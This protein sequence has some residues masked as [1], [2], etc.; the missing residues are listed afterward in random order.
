MSIVLCNDKNGNPQLCGRCKTQLEK[1][2]ECGTDYYPTHVGVVLQKY[3]SSCGIMLPL[4]KERE[5]DYISHNT[6]KR[7]AVR[8]AT[9]NKRGYQE[10]KDIVDNMRN[11]DDRKSFIRSF[12]QR[13]GIP[14]EK[15]INCC[16]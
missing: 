1:N 8:V 5:P 4:V 12:S 14:S 15:I 13:I 11:I 7:I 2:P 6:K 3:C 10:L 16:F 9:A